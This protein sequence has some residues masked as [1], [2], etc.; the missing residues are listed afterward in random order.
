MLRLLKARKEKNIDVSLPQSLA[1]RQKLVCLDLEN[2]LIVYSNDNS[3]QAKRRESFPEPEEGID[4]NEKKVLEEYH[5][6]P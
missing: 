4:D 5:Y 1:K 3:N 2:F 6:L